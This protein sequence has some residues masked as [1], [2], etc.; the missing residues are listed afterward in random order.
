MSK[1][2]ETSSGDQL[3]MNRFEIG[4]F[5]GLKQLKF[6]DLSRLNLIVGSND[7][8][9]TSVLE[10]LAIYCNPLD[11]VEWVDVARARDSNSPV[12]TVDAMTS[13]DAVRW[14]FPH[15]RNLEGTPD[16]HGPISLAAEGRTKI[17][18]VDATCSP[19]RGIPPVRDKGRG[20]AWQEDPQEEDGWSVRIDVADDTPKLFESGGQFSEFPMWNFSGLRYTPRPS[21]SRVPLEYLPPYSHRNASRQLSRLTNAVKDASRPDVDDLLRDLD[22]QIEGTEIITTADGRRPLLAVRHRSAGVIPVSVLGDGVR[23]AM[24]LAL[25]VNRAKGGLLIVDEIEAA[26]HVTALDRLYP[27][28]AHAC[29]TENVQ[30]IAT[31]HSLEA[32]DTI[33]GLT[34]ISIK[35]LA[36]YQLHRGAEGQE[37]KRYTGGMLRRLVHESGLDVR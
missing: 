14:M 35:E 9:K 17:V 27:W 28:L 4:S 16:E 13:A 3:L 7:S 8:G 32:I 12:N 5:R 22:P 25:A 11:L 19:F 29:R 10:A 6:E 34:S 15:R 33:S 23:R 36:G 21:R 18:R 1:T 26:L 2:A 30:M 31:T 37:P 20:R 24:S